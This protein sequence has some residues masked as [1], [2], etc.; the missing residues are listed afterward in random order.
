MKTVVWLLNNLNGI[1]K[2]VEDISVDA[3]SGCKFCSVVVIYDDNYNIN[4]YIILT[5][6]T[7]PSSPLSQWRYQLGSSSI[8]LLHIISVNM[9]ALPYCQVGDKQE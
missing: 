4:K 3:A 1:K 2:H 8:L 7:S 5:R 6:V 9:L